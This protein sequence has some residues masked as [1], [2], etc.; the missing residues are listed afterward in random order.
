[1][2]DDPVELHEAIRQVNHANQA[3]MVAGY[4]WNWASKYHPNAWDITIE[5]W[6]YR[7]RWNLSKDG[8]VWIMKP[9]TV[10]EV[11]CIHTCQGLELETIGVIIGPDLA[12]RDGQVVTV[13]SARARTDQSLKGYKVGLKRDP[14]AIRLK[15]DAIIRNTY[16]TL[17]SRGTKACWVFA[18]DPELSAWLKQISEKTPDH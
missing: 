3:R 6:G 16:R 7:A 9:G 12:Y 1:V 5:P 11:G 13:P 2:F 14:Q 8:S 4:C 15:A 10:E 17:M 18:C